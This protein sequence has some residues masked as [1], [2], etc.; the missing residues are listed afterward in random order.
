M[1][2]TNPVN[3]HRLSPVQPSPAQPLPTKQCRNI[4]FS[5]Q[6]RRLAGLVGLM[7]TVL[8]NSDLAYGDGDASITWA[9]LANP[10]LCPPCFTKTVRPKTILPVDFAKDMAKANLLERP[11]ELTTAGVEPQVFNTELTAVIHAMNTYNPRS[12]A[13]DREYIG[14]VYRLLNNQGYIYSTTPGNIGADQISGGVPKLKTARLI[15]FWHTHG[16]AHRTRKYFSDIDT[17]LVKKWGLPFYMGSADGYLR[18]FRPEHRTLSFRQAREKGLGPRT[19]YGKG[20]LIRDVLI[21][22]R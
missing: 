3:L 16:A 10:N 19:G 15:A 5:Q 8:L 22:V 14:A 11:S 21:R 7:A 17:D 20:E 13:E 6:W 4:S 12:V 1:G 18:V 9:A 2:A